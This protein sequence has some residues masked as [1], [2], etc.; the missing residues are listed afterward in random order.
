MGRYM[1]RIFAYDYSIKTS[2]TAPI[3]AAI[4]LACNLRLWAMK[5]LTTTAVIVFLQHYKFPNFL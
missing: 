1:C 4:K 5:L 2:V 3:K